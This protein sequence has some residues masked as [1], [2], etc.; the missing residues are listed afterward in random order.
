M[1]AF[2]HAGYWT[3]PRVLALL[4]SAAL[5]AVLVAANAHLVAVSISSQPDCVPHLRAPV[6]GSAMYRAAMSSC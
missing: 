6:E 3:R 4:T 2:L 5:A 1:K